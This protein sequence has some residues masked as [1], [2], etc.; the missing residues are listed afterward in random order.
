MKALDLLKANVSIEKRAEKFAVSIKRNI[1][2]DL[3]QLTAKKENIEDQLF[4]LTNFSLST[5][6]NK[7]LRQM[8]KEDCEERFRKAIQLEYELKLLEVEIKIKTDSFNT[9]FG[10]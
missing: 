5:D 10:E 1:Q 8:T 3:D 4:E 7:G 6:L 9:Y 2:R